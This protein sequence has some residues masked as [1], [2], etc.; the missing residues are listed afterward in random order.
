MDTGGLVTFF[1]YKCIPAPGRE[2]RDT[3]GEAISR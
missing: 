1:N 2:H 3:A